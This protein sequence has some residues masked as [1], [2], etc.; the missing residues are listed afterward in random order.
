MVSL[1]P[2]TRQRLSYLLC[3][4]KE[5]SF[6]REGPRKIKVVALSSIFCEG[7]DKSFAR[8]GPLLLFS[9]ALPKRDCEGKDKSLLKSK[10]RAT[11]SKKA[12]Y[13]FL[14]LLFLFSFPWLFFLKR[15]EGTLAKLLFFPSHRIRPSKTNKALYPFLVFLFLF[16]FPWLFFLKREVCEALFKSSISTKK[17]YK[18]YARGVSSF[19]RDKSCFLCPLSKILTTAFFLTKEKVKASHRKSHYVSLAAHR[20]SLACCFF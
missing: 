1:L 17:G 18:A 9:V 12:L 16:S 8:E 10:I 20:I 2:K 13:P 4:G 7:K 5:K 19:A 6:A 11:E 3:E 15:E 14:V